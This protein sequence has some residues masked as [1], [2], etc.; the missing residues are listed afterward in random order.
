[1]LFR[2]SGPLPDESLQD[3]GSDGQFGLSSFHQASN[4]R[5]S[6]KPQ[7]LV[8]RSRRARSSPMNSYAIT[9]ATIIALPSVNVE[10][11]KPDFDGLQLW[12]DDVSRLLDESSRT[13]ASTS[14]D[15]ERATDQDE[16]LIGSRYFSKPRRTLSS[17]ETRAEK[18]QNDEISEVVI[19]LSVAKGVY[20]HG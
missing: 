15:A 11:T 2:S 5:S 17:T 20:I 19:K 6:V 8:T 7:V 14:P 10:L 12:A 18:H 9:V 3:A 4:V 13:S 16:S 1:M